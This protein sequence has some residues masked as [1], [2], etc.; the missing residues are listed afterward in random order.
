MKRNDLTLA[1]ICRA[2]DVS[3]QELFTI[4]NATDACYLPTEEGR[5]RHTITYCSYGNKGSANGY[6]DTYVMKSTDIWTNHPDPQFL[7]QCT[8]INP[9]HIHGKWGKAHKRDYISRGEMPL[10]LTKHIAEMAMKL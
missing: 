9:P 5:P 3:E 2:M 6:T 7:Q 8:T 1:D 4:C 10:K